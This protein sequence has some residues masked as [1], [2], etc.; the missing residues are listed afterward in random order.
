MKLTKIFAVA[1]AA[2]ALTACNDDDFNTSDATVEMQ[3]TTMSVNEDMVAGTYY[4]V[5][6]EVL[7]ETNGP[8]SVTVEVNAV[9]QNPATEGEHYLI[10]DKTITI[11]KGESIGYIEFYPVSNDE[12]NEDRQFSITITN[13]QGATIGTQATCVITLLDN[14]RFLPMKYAEIQGN[15]TL[16]AKSDYDGAPIDYDMEIWG[17][18]EGETGYLSTLYISGWAGYD[19]MIAT[20]TMNYDITTDECLLTLPLGQIIAEDV[21]FGSFVG[22]VGLAYGYN[23]GGW[24]VVTSGAFTAIANSEL[25][26]IEFDKDDAIMEII[27]QNGSLYSFMDVYSGI[28]ISRN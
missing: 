11:P 25:T 27:Y 18:D 20:M 17:V 7:G 23:D 19:W 4:K 21:D 28:V 14:D 16:T 24:Y 26:T 1:F 3:N 8:I 13:A 5:P 15:W 9:S 12:I 22:D 2:V 10:T 6:I